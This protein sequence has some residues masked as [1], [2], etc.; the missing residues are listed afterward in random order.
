LF[1]FGVDVISQVPI[2][3]TF[4]LYGQKSRAFS[5]WKR[6]VDKVNGAFFSSLEITSKTAYMFFIEKCG[7]WKG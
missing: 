5:E 7:F 1:G 6:M 3:I 2:T 4:C